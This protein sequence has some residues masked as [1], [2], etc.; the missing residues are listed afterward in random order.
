[1]EGRNIVV[2]GGAGFIGSN[3]VRTLSSENEVIVID[4]LSI[5]NLSNINDL[6]QNKSITFIKGSVTDL[7]FLQKI[8][9]NVDYVFHE[10]AIPSVPRSIENP[11]KSNYANVN[12]TINVLVAARDNNADKVVYASSSSIYGDTP[13]LPKRENMSPNPLSPYAVSKVCGEYYCKV[14]NEVY[15]LATASLRYFNVFGP[16]QDP[17]SKYAAVVPNFINRVL[18][19][20]SPVVYG[21]GLQTRDF[22][23]IKDVVNANILAA[24]S[25]SIGKFNIAGGKRVSIN[26]LAKMVMKIMRKDLDLI[27]KDSRLGDIMHSLADIS[28]AK[29]ELNYEPRFTLYKGLEET[30]EWFLQVI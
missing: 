2:T 28:K 22:T 1:M 8:F 7:D 24:E 11:I 6:I 9:K 23:Y 3:I 30:I 5:G 15:G 17:S 4:D 19:D 14:F 26:D 27:Y 20:S 21:D 12:G 13:T 18:N 10:A 29:K 25:N 16:R